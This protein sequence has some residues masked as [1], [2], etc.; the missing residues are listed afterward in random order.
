MLKSFG[1][2]EAGGFVF[3]RCWQSEVGYDG[4]HV[5][6]CVRV[7]QVALIIASYRYPTWR[8][9]AKTSGSGKR[10]GGRTQVIGGG[11]KIK[12]LTK[13]PHGCGHG[14]DRPFIRR[15][16]SPPP[17]RNSGAK[18]S[19]YIGCLESKV[20]MELFVRP[21]KDLMVLRRHRMASHTR[22]LGLA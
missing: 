17:Q 5:K 2:K 4:Q 16:K 3:G 1:R 20:V 21:Q 22:L 15:Q 14:G 9:D 6:S 8:T 12:L 19:V 10:G 7:M 18:M 11:D 13:C